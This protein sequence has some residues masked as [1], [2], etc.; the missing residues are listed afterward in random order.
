MP[1]NP[2]VR[3]PPEAAPAGDAA[4]S[5]SAP[6]QPLRMG[7]TVLVMAAPGVVLINNETGG[8]IPTGVPTP[9]T[10]TVTLLRR[11]RDGDLVL[12]P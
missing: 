12:A 2:I 4:P 1:K 7:D 8:Y 5:T 10:V 3:T 9:Q 6:A 11:L